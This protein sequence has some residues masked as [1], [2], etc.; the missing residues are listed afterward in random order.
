MKFNLSTEIVVLHAAARVTVVTIKKMIFQRRSILRFALSV[1][2][3]D[4]HTSYVHIY[5]WVI[6]CSLR[7]YFCMA[8]NNIVFIY[9]YCNNG[10]CARQTTIRSSI[11]VATGQRPS[12]IGLEYRWHSSVAWLRSMAIHT[13][14]SI[15]HRYVWQIPVSL[16]LLLSSSPHFDI[17]KTNENCFLL[18]F[19]CHDHHSICFMCDICLHTCSILHYMILNQK[20]NIECEWINIYRHTLAMAVI[21]KDAT[22]AC[23]IA[24]S[25]SNNEF[26]HILH[27]F[28]QR[29]YTSFLHEPVC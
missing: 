22:M 6:V 27:L 8:I 4:T 14:S 26:S 16:S 11:C 24:V 12:R 5:S 2:T 23:Y 18:S 15:A 7:W 13:L 25:R 17:M 10:H 9:S 19:F 1:C 29:F 28:L 20:T 3:G 21:L